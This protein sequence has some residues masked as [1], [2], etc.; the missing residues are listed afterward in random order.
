[1]ATPANEQ[2]WPLSTGDDIFFWGG[3]GGGNYKVSTHLYVLEKGSASG[4][5][6]PVSVESISQIIMLTGS[7]ENKPKQEN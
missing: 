4:L 6:K 2:K 3:R 1:M 5:E 7:M